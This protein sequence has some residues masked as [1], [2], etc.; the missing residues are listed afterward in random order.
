MPEEFT[1][2]REEIDSPLINAEGSISGT[3]VE[4][5]THQVRMLAGTGIGAIT[6][7]SITIPQQMGNEEKYGSPTYHYDPKTGSTYNSMGLPNI[8]L[9]RAKMIIPELLDIAH[10]NGKPLIVSVS[11]TL[12]TSEIG[13]PYDQTEKLVETILDLEVDGVVVNMSCPNLVVEGGGRKPMIG[14]DLDAS[15]ELITTLERVIGTDHRI[16]LK[17]PPYISDSD[18]KMIP[19]LADMILETSSIGFIITSNTIPNKVAIDEH[20]KP[21]LSVPSGAGG[22]SGPVT[23]EIGRLQ[24]HMWLEHL[25]GKKEIISVLGVDTGTELA[26]RVNSGASAAGGVT[27]LWESPNWGRAVTKMLEEYI[28]YES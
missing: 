27:F 22:L 25:L 2:L 1:L 11:P 10:N 20:C 17:L 15:A 7:G 26:Y 19:A 9:T 3:N 6:I 4:E 28:E 13:D 12:S 24:L 14:Y 16:G 18:K 23:K 8:G 5:I 21:I